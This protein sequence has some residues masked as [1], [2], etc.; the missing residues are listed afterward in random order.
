M[1][2]MWILPFSL[3]AIILIGGGG[4]YLFPA[5]NPLLTASAGQLHKWVPFYPIRCGEILFEK[6]DPQTPHYSFCIGEIRKRVAIYVQKDISREDV[7]DP[8]VQ[9]HWRQV[10]SDR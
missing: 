1:R 3:V 5:R 9:V 7:M 10:M 6:N 2:S 4:Y 8:R